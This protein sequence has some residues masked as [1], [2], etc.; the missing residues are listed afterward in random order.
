MNL[1]IFNFTTLTYSSPRRLW[2]V[3]ASKESQHGTMHYLNVFESKHD[4]NSIY[5]SNSI[6]CEVSIL[7]GRKQYLWWFI[8]LLSWPPY[9]VAH[10]C[11]DLCFP[12]KLWFGVTCALWLYSTLRSHKRGVIHTRWNEIHGAESS[13][14]PAVVMLCWWQCQSTLHPMWDGQLFIME[15]LWHL[16]L[17]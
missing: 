10:E 17:L 14:A 6:M 1:F 15:Q 12:V 2:N 11:N 9:S 5:L 7:L 3:V 13:C 8:F 16:L 4:R